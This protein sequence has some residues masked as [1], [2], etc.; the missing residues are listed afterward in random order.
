MKVTVMSA[1]PRRKEVGGRKEGNC[2]V[3]SSEENGGRIRE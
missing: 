3:G 1:V 2:C